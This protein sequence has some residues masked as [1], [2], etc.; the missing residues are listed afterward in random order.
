VAIARALV[1]HPEILLADEPT[2]NL[3]TAT[4]TEIFDILEE[5]C[6][7]SG[8]TLLLVTH[9]EELARRHVDRVLRMQDG[10]LLS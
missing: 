10:R 1:N 2:G 8:V 3:D 5:N 4:A 9:D 7:R 6:R